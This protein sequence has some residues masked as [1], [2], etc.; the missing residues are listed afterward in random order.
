M[1]EQR[2]AP[3]RQVFRV[4][5]RAQ[6]AVRLHHELMQQLAA[7]S[8]SMPTRRGRQA[9]RTMRGTSPRRI[10]GHERNV[11]LAHVAVALHGHQRRQ[12][13]PAAAC[14]SAA[15][16]ARFSIARHQCADRGRQVGEQRV[17]E[18]RDQRLERR[19]PR[20]RS[21]PRRGRPRPAPPCARAGSPRSARSAN[22][23]F[24][25]SCQTSWNVPRPP[26]TRRGLAPFHA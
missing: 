25:A 20:R 11:R 3:A 10:C 5:E 4:R 12:R 9:R 23:G 21:A 24:Q 26:R 7:A 6:R 17:L 1:L 14:T 22:S 15:S 19:R 2:L 18:Q 16:A 13:R 8:S